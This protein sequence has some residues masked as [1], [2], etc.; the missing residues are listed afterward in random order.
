MAK[1]GSIQK[2][3]E[4]YNYIRDMILYHQI[5]PGEKVPELEI[6]QKLG[7]SRTPVR[8]AIRRLAWEGLLN[9]DTN[10]GATV[11]VLTEE[12]M[13]DLA[14][15]RIKNDELV[16]PL[17]IY[18]G[19]PRN[20]KELREIANLCMEANNQGNMPLRHALDARFHLKI[21]EIA[22]NEVMY[23]VQKMLNLKI[24]FWQNARIVSKDILLDGL[25]EHFSV[26]DFLEN[27]DIVNA[28]RVLRNHNMVS[29][30][31]DEQQIHSMQISFVHET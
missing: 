27:G 23:H 18:N 24:Q 25:Q 14:L 16:I 9:L 20:F 3:E 22:G 8:E 1:L 26:V 2:K 17:A 28:T 7:V 21:V 12:M 5:H 6:A 30:H 13:R 31:L 11:I 19:S 29:Y 15:V 10:R 4:I